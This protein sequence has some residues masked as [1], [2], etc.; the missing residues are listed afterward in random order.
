[1]QCKNCRAYVVIVK[2]QG[3]GFIV[4]CPVCDTTYRA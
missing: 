2:W 3:G 4:R 1:M